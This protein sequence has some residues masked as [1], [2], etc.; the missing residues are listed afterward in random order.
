[1]C[2]AHLRS[3]VAAA[4]Y[5]C[6]NRVVGVRNCKWLQRMRVQNNESQSVWQQQ[7]YK[8]FPP[9][10]TAP[11]AS[12]PS[13]YAMPVQ[14]SITDATFD[15]SRDEVVVK[16]YAYAGGGHGV[17]RVDVSY[18]GGK[19]F[20]GSAKFIPVPAGALEKHTPKTKRDSWAWRQLESR[21]PT[22]SIRAQPVPCANANDQSC[23]NVC[24]KAITD[25]QATQ[26]PVA[27]YN[28]RGL[29]YNGYS[30]REVSIGG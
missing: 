3:S 6:R 21:T 29:L 8:N 9:W 12:L 14:S 25:D 24:L 7:D 30:C 26:P 10:A 5:R 13:V 1:M 18:D 22:E 15:A 2:F 28:F 27:A 4:L 23:Y 11:D 20:E 19:T 17:Q 16:G